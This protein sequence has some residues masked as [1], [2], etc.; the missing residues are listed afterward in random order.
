[1]AIGSASGISVTD[2]QTQAAA[3]LG[4]EVVKAADAASD[5]TYPNGMQT[6]VYVFNDEAA[7]AFA[8]GN[9]VYRDPSATTFG[10]FGGLRTPTAAHQPKVMCLGVAQHA[11]AAGSYGFILKQGAGQVLAGAAG[12][13]VDSA[14]TTGGSVVGTA[15]VWADDTAGANIGVIGHTTAVIAGG[16]LGA[17][18]VDCG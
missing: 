8:V 1:M 10:L 17:V 11:I 2:V 16:A 7:A 15:L 5:G 12:V 14:F 18:W 13:A 6:W 9:I 3:P 4:F